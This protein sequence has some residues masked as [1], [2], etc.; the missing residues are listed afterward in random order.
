[1][2]GINSQFLNPVKNRFLP[3]P[4]S[5]VEGLEHEPTLADFTFIKELGLGSYGEVHLVSH[6]KTKAQYALKCIDKSLPENIEEKESFFREVEI[7]Y[8]LNHPNIVK[9]YGHF[10]DED[11][12]YFL[13]QYIQKK[14]YI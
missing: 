13:I 9:L 8:K 1:M 6:N 3:L 12:C 11:F 2:I 7:M 5:A 10:E 4:K 14:K